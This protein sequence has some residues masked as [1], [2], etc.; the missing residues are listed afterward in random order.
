MFASDD[1]VLDLVNA[2]YAL[3]IDDYIIAEEKLYTVLEDK[4]RIKYEYRF[5]SAQ[6]FLF[7][8]NPAGYEKSFIEKIIKERRIVL[9][10]KELEKSQRQNN[11]KT[12]QGN[13]STGTGKVE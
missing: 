3:S 8:T 2:I 1:H 7:E 13:D 6:A 11:N 12:I 10:E 9:H 5:K 4:D